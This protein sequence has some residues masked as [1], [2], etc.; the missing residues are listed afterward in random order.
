[1]GWWIAIAVVVLLAAWL[2]L[3]YNGLIAARNRTQEAWSEIE[4]TPT[5]STCLI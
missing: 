4:V 2:F 3:T 5:P 1:M